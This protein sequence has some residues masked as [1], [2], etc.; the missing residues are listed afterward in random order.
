M[1]QPPWADLELFLAI[2]RAGS[3][4]GAAERTRV[5]VSTLSRRLAA[6]EELLGAT[7]FDRTRAGVVPTP[8]ARALLE[9]AARMDEA[10]NAFVRTRESFEADVVGEVRITV[11]PSVG[12]VFLSDLL[13]GLEAAHPKLSVVIDVT[14]TVR[15]IE[16]RQADLALRFTRPAGGE[17]AVKRLARLAHRLLAAPKLAAALGPVTDWG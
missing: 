9:P 2:F 16:R 13:E 8:L 15:D 11:T 6:L 10:A 4:R 3:L 12:D 5:D 14:N 1:Q 17:L 7:L